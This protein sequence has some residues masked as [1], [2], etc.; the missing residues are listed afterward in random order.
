M[1]FLGAHHPNDAISGHEDTVVGAFETQCQPTVLCSC[2]LATSIAFKCREKTTL[3]V[4]QD[5]Y[6]EW[7]KFIIAPIGVISEHFSRLEVDKKSTAVTP[8]VYSATVTNIYDIL[9]DSDST[10]S[11]AIHLAANL[12]KISKLAKFMDGH[13]VITIYSLSIQRCNHVA[14]YGKFPLWLK[15]GIL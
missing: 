7:D 15:Q 13:Y 10:Y 4:S 8:H 14:C 2:E 9:A 12:K 5:F 11:P 6:M 3:A 1:K